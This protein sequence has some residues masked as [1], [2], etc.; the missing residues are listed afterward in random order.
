MCLSSSAINPIRRTHQSGGSTSS[1]R[2]ETAGKTAFEITIDHIIPNI[3]G[4][5][6]VQATIQF[7]LAILA[8]AGLSYLGVG[9]QP[10]EPELGSRAGTMPKPS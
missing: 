4:L 10:I 3:A 2:R 8:E 5:I 9:T 7:A 6:I 1:R